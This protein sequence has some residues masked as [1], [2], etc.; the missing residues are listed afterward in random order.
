MFGDLIYLLKVT[1]PVIILDGLS[2]KPCYLSLTVEILPLSWLPMLDML[3][4][5]LVSGVSEVTI[6]C[7]LDVKHL[8][9]YHWHSLA[10]FRGTFLPQ[11]HSIAMFYMLLSGFIL[12]VFGYMVDGNVGV[13]IIALLTMLMVH[14]IEFLWNSGCYFNRLIHDVANNCIVMLKSS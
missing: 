5:T 8:L 9:Q 14:S 3:Y 13:V 4:Y 1:H 6:C 11:W 7:Q 2:Q 12:L 10:K